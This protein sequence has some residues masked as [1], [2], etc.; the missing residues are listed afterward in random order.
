MQ[1]KAVKLA[2]IRV[3]NGPGGR[4]TADETNVGLRTRNP[5]LIGRLVCYGLCGA[6]ATLLPVRQAMAQIDHDPGSILPSGFLDVSTIPPAPASPDLNPYG[7]AFVPNGFPSGGKIS[8]GDILVSNF[9]DRKNIQGTGITITRVAP[10]GETSTFFQGTFAPPTDGGLTTALGV[11]HGGFVVVGQ[12]PNSNG[13][14]NGTPQQ[15][16]LLFLDKNGTLALKYPNVNGP[17][18]LAI[19]DHFDLAEIF[20]SNVLD[21]TVVRLDVTV[22][23]TTVSVTKNT[24]IAKGYPHSLSAVAFVLGPT[25]LAF[26]AQADILYVASTSDNQIF[27]IQNAENTNNP[28]DKGILVYA[29]QVHLHGP[30]ALAL[31][32][33]GNLLTSNGDAINVTPPPLP[34]N[35]LPSEIIEFTKDGQFIGQLSIDSAPGAAFGIA[36][37][38]V[39]GSENTAR[40]ALVNDDD[41]TIIVQTLNAGE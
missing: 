27:K 10:D 3:A 30:L 21:G 22:G 26:D 28:V 20:V 31:T 38:P 17:W 40:I 34:P 32:P 39:P 35:Q 24:V 6:A 2:T 4:V 9:N 12:L 33:N 41:N 15:G 25:G 36:I 29:D 23:P 5:R 14:K 16:S 11:L 18:D 37:A 13:N 1:H 7:V 19:D 8:P